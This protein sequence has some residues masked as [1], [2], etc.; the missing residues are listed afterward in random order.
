MLVLERSLADRV[1]AGE[2]H[3]EDAYAAANDPDTLAIL[4]KR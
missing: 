4:L 2:I 1:Q 3:L